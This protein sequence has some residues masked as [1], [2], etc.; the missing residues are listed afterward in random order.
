MLTKNKKPYPKEKIDKL[1]GK[2]KTPEQREAEQKA[3]ASKPTVNIVEDPKRKIDMKLAMKEAKM[4]DNKADNMKKQEI[5]RSWQELFYICYG[6][7][8]NLDGKEHGMTKKLCKE[9]LETDIKMAMSS[10]FYE[11]LSNDW[12]VSRNIV[13]CLEKFVKNFNYWK[14]RSYAY[15]DSMTK[16]GE[17][18]GWWLM[19]EAGLDFKKLPPDEIIFRTEKSGGR[20]KLYVLRDKRIIPTIFHGR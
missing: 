1:L 7:V 18:N 17:P 6:T 3:R 9:A 13:P 15:K 20:I 4:A 19:N 8:Y 10:M 5:V 2:D 16:I 11:L 12:Y 14:S